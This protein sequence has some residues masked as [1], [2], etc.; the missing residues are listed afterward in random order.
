MI[1]FCLATPFVLAAL[2]GCATGSDEYPSLAVRDAERVAGTAEPVEAY[3]PPAPS[4]AVLDRLDDLVAAAATAHRSFLAAA[5][6]ARQRVSAARNAPVASDSWSAAQVALAALESDRARAIVSLAE[7]DQLYAAAA[8][9]GLALEKI[10]A[11]R[12]EVAEMVEVEN[13]TIAP[14]LAVLR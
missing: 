6:K 1:R 5:P 7:L 2:A 12:D 14:L 11:A 10:A 8:A 13:E 4:P 3:I 9:E